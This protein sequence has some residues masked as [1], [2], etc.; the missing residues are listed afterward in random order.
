M[1]RLSKQSLEGL[2]RQLRPDAIYVLVDGAVALYHSDA[3]SLIKE[4]FS[5]CYCLEVEGGESIKSFDKIE[6]VAHW[7]NSK[8]ATRQ[9]LLLAIGGGA[10]LDFAGFLA[11]IYKRGIEVVYLPTTLLA[12]VDASIGGKTAINSLGVK[13]LLGVI[14]EPR[15]ILFKP[16]FLKTLSPRDFLSGY[17]EL[18]KYG[19]LE[20]DPLWSNLLHHPLTDISTL[21]P[22]IEQAYAI[23][24][25]YVTEDLYDQGIRR[26]LNLGH[27]IGHA[28]EAL[29]SKSSNNHK[30]RHGEAVILGLICELYIAH[31]R[32]GFPS[33]R[34]HQLSSFA[35][36]NLPRFSISCQDYPPLIDLLLQ[37]KKNRNGEVRMILMKDLGKPIEE[38]VSLSE[39]EASF[40]YY[41]DSFGF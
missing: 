33:I 41:R 9:S 14:R 3:I 27:T 29:S 39:I 10:L 38:S 25:R 40:D 28:F 1:E 34:L 30:L 20:G 2:V 15:A 21:S 17:G 4:S 6:E 31:H 19:L 26:F 18:L 32:S 24:K 5:L 12:M 36:D 22:Y 7:L 37:D 23:K 8:G 16:S 11:A 13:N 35:K